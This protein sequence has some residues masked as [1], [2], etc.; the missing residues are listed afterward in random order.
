MHICAGESRGGCV[1]VCVW[2]KRTCHAFR[3]LVGKIMGSTCTSHTEWS[4]LRH[5]IWLNETYPGIPAAL[6]PV[7]IGR[8]SRWSNFVRLLPGITAWVVQPIGPLTT[9]PTGNA[10]FL[11]SITLILNLKKW[12]SLSKTRQISIVDYCRIQKSQ[13]K[14]FKITRNFH[15]YSPATKKLTMV[16][17]SF[18]KVAA[19]ILRRVKRK[20]NI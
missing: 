19:Y 12:W 9:V 1:C 17:P 14:Y 16:S 4:T 8:P 10:K 3:K 2:R 5:H 6:R 13:A 15:S 11:L 20:M 18:N 7:D